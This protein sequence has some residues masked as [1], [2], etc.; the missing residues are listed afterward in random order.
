VARDVVRVVPD[1][2]TLV[3]A[4]SMP[5]RDVEWYA[6]PRDGGRI[7]SN[8]GANGIDG[9]VSTAV[10]VAL[11]T[12]GSTLA[13]VGDIAFVHDANA[14]VAAAARGIDLVVVVVHNDGGGIFS[15]L[16]QAGL[17][18]PDRFE[19]LLGTPHGVD[20]ERLASGVG[21]AAETVTEADGVAPTVEAAIE[22]GGVS[23]VVVPTD[24]QA[25]VKVHD[26]LNAAVAEA[27]RDGRSRP[28]GPG[29]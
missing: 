13:L 27:I 5:I 28:G 17:L 21:V 29:A 23:V 25:N 16:P 2:G 15:F 7:V 12:G 11:G 10:G 6:A 14:L 4:S 18:P 24:R 9:V 19:R 8:R 20:I 3:V 1:E 26:E 22:R